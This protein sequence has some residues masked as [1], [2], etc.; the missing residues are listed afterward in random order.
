MA[1]AAG[2]EATGAGVAQAPP[3]AV[4]EAVAAMAVDDDISHNL[5]GQRLG[6]KGRDTRDRILLAATRLLY[7][8]R[9]EVPI[10]MSAVAREASLGMTSLYN[11]FKDLSELLGAV[12]EGVMASAEDAYLAPLRRRWDDAELAARCYEFVRGYHAFWQQHSYLLHL[13][14]ALSDKADPVMTRQRIKSTQPIIALIVEQMGGD[15]QAPRSHIFATAT[16]LMIG[17]ERSVTISTDNDLPVKMAQD[18][19]HDDDHFL[20]PCARLM[21]M[22]IRDM[23]DQRG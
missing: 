5:Q 13:R 23:R 12:L 4:V 14:N 22:A 19:Q 10:S 16:V 15:P 11:Y 2:A 17:I 18:I 20:R 1:R 6:R 7:C 9:R 21:E 3:P 8:D